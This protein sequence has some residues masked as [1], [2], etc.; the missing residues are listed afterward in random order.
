MRE[1]RGD[2]FR[3]VHDLLVEVARKDPTAISQWNAQANVFTQALL[4][5]LDFSESPSAKD[6]EPSD[7]VFVGG[8]QQVANPQ[9][10]E[11]AGLL[12]DLLDLS[13]KNAAS[14]FHVAHSESSEH[15][16]WS[17]L[18]AAVFIYIQDWHYQLES[19]ILAITHF[20][21]RVCISTANILKPLVDRL[22][23]VSNGIP[24]R[25]IELATRIQAK[26]ASDQMVSG[27]A[28]DI[29]CQL[30][31][32]DIE[33]DLFDFYKEHLRK[34]L[35]RVGDMCLLYAARW[36]L[37]KDELLTVIQELQQV[38]EADWISN[39]KLG[40]ALSTLSR[41][42]S[43]DDWRFCIS[44]TDYQDIQATIMKEWQHPVM[45]GVLATKWLCYIQ[46][47]TGEDAP[48]NISLGPS[49]AN[50]ERDDFGRKW[51]DFFGLRGQT[52]QF[53]IDYLIPSQK[54]TRE[55]AL[56]GDQSSALSSEDDVQEIFWQL[57]QSITDELIVYSRK[58]LKDIKVTNEDSLRAHDETSYSGR[59]THHRERTA[60]KSEKINLNESTA[61]ETFLLLLT[62]LY[63]DRPDQAI[64]FWKDS[65]EDSNL[66]PSKYTETLE[67]QS[68]LK[69]AADV[70]TSRFL[71]V[72][73]GMLASLATGK[74][75]ANE[76]HS[77]LNS[78]HPTSQ[79]G[80]IAWTT[81]F[82]SLTTAT[83]SLRKGGPEMKAEE[84]EVI[85][86]FLRLL[87]QVVK[88]SYSA[89]RVLCDNQRMKA[90]QKLFWLLVCR[91]PVDLKGALL[92]TLAAFCVRSDTSQDIHQQVWIALEQSM[93]VPLNTDGNH[94]PRQV[95]RN[96]YRE[97]ILFDLEEIESPSG[98][99][100]ETQAYMRLLDT[101]LQGLAWESLSPTLMQLGAPNRL[102][103]VRPYVKFV[104]DHIFLKIQL[105]HFVDE[106]DRWE[107]MYT[108]LSI[109]DECV[110][111]FDLAKLTADRGTE[112][113]RATN[114]LHNTDLS[115]RTLES[116]ALHPGFDI[117]CK[118]LSNSK[119][120]ERL[121]GLLSISVQVINN[122]ND[123][124]PLKGSCVR[125]ASSIL[126]Q[127]LRK[128]RLFLEVLAPALLAMQAEKWLELPVP[129]CGAD[130]LLVSRKDV[131][132][133]I[134]LLV[135][136]K[137]ESIVLSAIHIINILCHSPALGA[138]DGESSVN[139]LIKIFESS[140]L[141]KE[142]LAGFRKRLAM[143]DFEEPFSWD[144]QDDPGDL[145]DHQL[146][147]NMSFLYENWQRHPQQ[148]S[149]A[150]MVHTIRTAIL[151]LFISNISQS[152][153]QLTLSHLLLGFPTGTARKSRS[154]DAST[155]PI[156]EYNCFHVILNLVRIPEDG[157]GTEEED[158]ITPPR[159]LF[160]THPRLAER[161]YHLLYVL[162]SD[163]LTS[164]STM[165]YLR[166]H[167]DWFT[168]Q[169]K[170][171]PDSLS[172]E[173]D[174]ENEDKHHACVMQRAW[175]LKLIALELHLTSMAQQR[176]DAERL[177]KILYVSHPG[178][179][180]GNSD[181]SL[182]QVDSEYEV[183][184][185]HYF[186]QPLPKILEILNSMDFD[187]VA[188]DL[189]IEAVASTYGVNLEDF[190]RVGV[191]DIRALHEHFKSF[192]N[193]Q[194][195]NV[196]E[197]LRTL[198]QANHQHELNSA[199]YQCAQAWAQVLQVT[200]AN[201]FVLLPSET[202][203]NLLFEILT[204]LLPKINGD[205][206]NPAIAQD[207]T[208]VVLVLL[209]K[210]QSDR[211]FQ[212]LTQLTSSQHEA[213]SST[214]RLPPDTLQQVILRGMLD[215]IVVPG[216]SLKV[217]GTLYVA[218]LRLFDYMKPEELENT[219][220]LAPS[221]SSDPAGGVWEV[222]GRDGA[223]ERLLQGNYAI[224]AGYG[225]RLLDII[226]RDAADGSGVWNI[227]AFA[228]LNGL[229]DM[230]STSS[231]R[232]DAKANEVLEVLAKRN[233]L[234]LFIKSITEDDDRSLQDSL[235]NT[236]DVVNAQLL[237]TLKISFML[238]LALTREGSRKLVE[239][240]LVEA[241]SDFKY[242]DI[243]G[244]GRQNLPQYYD[245][246]QPTLSLIV[247][248]ATQLIPDF[249]TSTKLAN[250][251]SAHRQMFTWILRDKEGTSLPHLRLQKDATALMM[252]LAD[253]TELMVSNA[254]DILSR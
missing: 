5:C 80:R 39:S 188:I 249:L 90:I 28:S 26:L 37:N 116:L 109:F 84:V 92:E 176:G 7:V 56:F 94:W 169:L 253:R 41:N 194:V 118:F 228:L 164:Q 51:R 93:I 210:M 185:D 187:E 198:L 206:T 38:K 11:Q 242:L 162:C 21:S 149:V 14:L 57:V 183:N 15:E 99:Y 218:L 117:F 17:T 110:R 219:S 236:S 233:Y 68:F 161:C 111:S 10:K 22:R 48:R 82:N 137:D 49:F 72:F 33:P 144:D 225:E 133:N 115:P 241:L 152:P 181:N 221:A 67:K 196:D 170:A 207:M 120:T 113:S 135:L 124:L 190:R 103:G 237:Y 167:E 195:T 64:S 160:E 13:F 34:L 123:T 130:Q 30:K 238:R 119:F 74:E 230:A 128:Q 132:V 231:K 97:G 24:C 40:S 148:I 245:I 143:E 126:L 63:R 202:R 168:R 178:G 189:N 53:M 59:F 52:Y 141:K 163:P 145:V 223:R 70:S 18:K 105:R 180:A 216:V 76:A 77:R 234:G 131:V 248:I 88:Y 208:T 211:R 191:Y 159:P 85:K 220:L 203:E 58:Y 73:L 174:L 200:L 165:R 12:A 151:D 239:Y 35:A 60:T 65:R 209:D 19:L 86:A 45:Q 43:T 32:L 31:R 184:P 227:V 83:E 81:L 23:G 62:I 107:T 8:R 101:L 122:S 61:W 250:F 42:I 125:L 100:P 140:D 98:R 71:T 3:R 157:D 215:Y 104:M 78:N 179:I 197:L 214:L 4:Q 156:D 246:V 244:D 66:D 186:E 47:T 213:R 146:T 217:R 36:G 108:C 222:D 205:Q 112:D 69:M 114:L 27:T 16:E 79:I 102:P 20:D 204:I 235:E 139:L 87:R 182:L 193:S 153:S 6:K 142:V 247:S 175:L 166:K 129:M 50:K 154:T 75:C 243:L 201:C 46:S 254:R 171:M 96:D 29:Q 9:F 251:V 172:I 173:S 91:T 212:S 177:T 2:Y 127:I 134:G 252:C 232:R 136:C 150:G 138:V 240:G 224:I 121:L 226:C 1:W 25:M 229:T 95:V 192:D 54:S 158:F 89:R 44:A 147:L 199:R 155:I 55:I 106:G